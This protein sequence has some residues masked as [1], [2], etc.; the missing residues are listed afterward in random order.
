M[1]HI[2]KAMELGDDNEIVLHDE[3][4]SRIV[5]VTDV[6]G[7]PEI[8][9]DAVRKHGLEKTMVLPVHHKSEGEYKSGDVCSD[10]Y[11]FNARGIPVVS[12]ISTPMYLFHDS[13]DVDKV[14]QESLEPVADMYLELIYKAWDIYSK[15]TDKEWR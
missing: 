6:Y 8:V 10:A 15:D 9:Y 11:D 14:H 3:S 2:G 12:I 1:E 7:L 5:Y 4:E 13:D